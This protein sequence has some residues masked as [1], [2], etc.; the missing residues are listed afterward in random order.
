MAIH[1]RSC[2]IFLALA[3]V[4]CGQ[5]IELAKGLSTNDAKPSDNTS[6][7]KQIE[8]IYDVDV[9]ANVERA[10]SSKVSAHIEPESMTENVVEGPSEPKAY[11]AQIED[12]ASSCEWS[13]EEESTQ[14]PNKHE[15]CACSQHL[16]CDDTS[17]HTDPNNHPN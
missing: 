9:E 10:P 16:D 11:T 3:M 2:A 4:S 17:Q 5:K 8:T 15:S 14:N 13:I 1:M 6:Q 7:P 12:E